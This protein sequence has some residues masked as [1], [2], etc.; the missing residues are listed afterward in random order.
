MKH[1]GVTDPEKRGRT[2]Q[3]GGKKPSPQGG[4]VQGE[5]DEEEEQGEQEQGY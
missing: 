1:M 2:G 5:E 4:R 3:Q